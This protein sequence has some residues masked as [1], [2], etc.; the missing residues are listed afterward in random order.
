MRQ[1]ILAFLEINMAERFGSLIFCAQSPERAAYI[2]DGCRRSGKKLV[3]AICIGLRLIF[4]C[5]N[6]LG[7]AG[8]IS[9]EK[10]G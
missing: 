10:N 7:C 4:T 3:A 5:E 2:N 6:L 8:F 9:S 1:N